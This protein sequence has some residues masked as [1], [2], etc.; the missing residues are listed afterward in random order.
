MTGAIAEKISMMGG[1]FDLVKLVSRPKNWYFRYWYKSEGNRRGNHIYRSLR[2]DDRTKAERL[3]FEEWRK[4]KTHELEVGSV[5]PKT[6]QD[7]MDDW[8][9]HTRRR[10]ITGEI[11]EV[12]YKSKRCKSKNWA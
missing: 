12:T 10:V 1:D 8:L 7:L 5:T 11:Q 3:A 9:E 2:T 4:L 6:P